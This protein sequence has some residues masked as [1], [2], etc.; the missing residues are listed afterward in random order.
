MFTLK[1]LASILLVLA[2]LMIPASGLAKELKVGSSGNEVW[3]LQWRLNDLGY[4]VGTVDGSF[5][6]ATEAAL[7]DFQQDNEIPE[8][9]MLD[10]T[11]RT[12][13]Y[14]DGTGEFP[15]PRGAFEVHAAA[16]ETTDPAPHGY[17]YFIDACDWEEAN[18]RADGLGGHL[19]SIDSLGEYTE[20]QSE[21]ME[22]QCSDV[23]FWIGAHRDHHNGHNA[24][25]FYWMDDD[26]IPCAEPIDFENQLGGLNPWALGKPR[27]RNEAGEP[28]M[29][30]RLSYNAG[31]LRWIWEDTTGQPEADSRTGYIVELNDAASLAGLTTEESAAKP[32]LEENP[33]PAA[34]E[35]SAG[36]DY[37]LE[38][39]GMEGMS[40]LARATTDQ[41]C[42]ITCVFWDADHKEEL[43]STT[44]YVDG[45]LRDHLVRV[46]LWKYNY[47]MLPRS[48]IIEAA[49]H[50]DGYESWGA[51]EFYTDW[52]TCDRYLSADTAV[53]PV[54]PARKPSRANRETDTWRVTT[55]R[56]SDPVHSD[57][58]VQVEIYDGDGNL[59]TTVILGDPVYLPSGI[60][61][62]RMAGNEDADIT[63]EVSGEPVI[64]TFMDIPLYTVAGH[65][66]NVETG[67]A[68]ANSVVTLEVQGRTYTATTDET[69]AYAFED[70]PGV[71]ARLTVEAPED[72]YLNPLVYDFKVDDASKDIPLA[73]QPMQPVTFYG[74]LYWDGN[75]AYDRYSQFC[76]DC[77]NGVYGPGAYNYTMLAK[78]LHVE[79]EKDDESAGVSVEAGTEYDLQCD[80]E[81][82][83]LGDTAKDFMF[84]AFEYLARYGLVSENTVVDDALYGIGNKRYRITGYLRANDTKDSALYYDEWYTGVSD[85]ILEVVSIEPAK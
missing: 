19:V 14:A 41:P 64:S 45:G 79:V 22:L 68:L 12:R 56:G 30:V 37:Q 71:N 51:S 44:D 77:E 10:E 72:A 59:V 31:E 4:R 33:A 3:E 40:V 73:I 23:A 66:V 8:T 67:E 42:R 47:R 49:L 70:V 13:L 15:E 81:M 57:P 25:D 46:S 36:A 84:A 34:A 60:Y 63:F 21:I 74:R 85:Q 69:G 61:T 24:K 29:Y 6:K 16:V 28:L 38:L 65:A 55:V 39:L 80:F 9:G 7:S 48:F 53:T 1:R 32:V 26:G 27:Y 62:A 82:T 35:P 17:L 58:A 83:N 52:V 78:T 5:G 50:R 2:L 11:T 54:R 75:E 43:F 20:L 76:E 18:R